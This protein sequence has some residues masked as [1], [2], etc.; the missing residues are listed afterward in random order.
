MLQ[1]M[2]KKTDGNSAA[3]VEQLQQAMQQREQAWKVRVSGAVLQ[4]CFGRWRP[5][6]TVV[7]GGCTLDVMQGLAP[8]CLPCALWCAVPWLMWCRMRGQTWPQKPLG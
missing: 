7:W 2:L 8:A 1:A 3:R 5:G 6:Q 4:V